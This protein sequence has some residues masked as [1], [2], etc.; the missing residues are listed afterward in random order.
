MNDRAHLRTSLKGAQVYLRILQRSDIPTTLQW[1][2]SEEISDIMG[3]LPVF[4]LEAQLEWFEKLKNDHSR[5]VFAICTH[6]D[7]HIGNVALGNIDMLHRHGMLSIFIAEK[8]DRAQGI[9]TESSR[10]LLGFAFEKLNLN[11]VYLRTSKRFTEAIRMYDRLGFQREGVMR[12]HTF[13]NGKYEDKIIYSMLRSEYDAIPRD[14]QPRQP[15][16]PTTP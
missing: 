3:Y 16:T 12:Q 10:L 15:L 4:T 13:S 8:V 11:K 14:E 7:R 9:G 5:Y 2:N 1:M 6:D